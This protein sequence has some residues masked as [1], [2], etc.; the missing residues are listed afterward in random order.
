MKPGWHREKRTHAMLVEAQENLCDW[1]IKN[2]TPESHAEICKRYVATH[3]GPAIK[4]PTEEERSA[5]GRSVSD[6]V[7]EFKAVV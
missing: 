7:N 1:N 6:V 2:S 4:V 3:L 5:S